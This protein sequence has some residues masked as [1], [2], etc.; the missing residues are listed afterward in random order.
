MKLKPRC[1]PCE[2]EGAFEQIQISVEDES[3]QLE[4][5][6]EVMDFLKEHSGDDIPPAKLGTLRNE[7]IR[8]ITEQEDPFGELKRKMNKTALELEPVA[9]EY[10]E[11]GSS[12]NGIIKRAIKVAAVGNSFDF[13]VSEHE[14][15]FDLLKKDF[16]QKLSEDLKIDHRDDLIDLLKSSENI[17]YLLDNPGEAIMD[18][19]FLKCINEVYPSAK[20]AIGARSAPVQDDIDLDMAET[21]NFQEYGDLLPS[22]RS[23]GY[24]PENSPP[25][26]KKFFDE[27]DL[28]ISKGQGNYEVLSE[29]E[30]N[31]GGKL[32]YLLRLKCTPVSKSL[33]AAKGNTVAALVK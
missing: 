1:I 22:G 10:I 4:V 11:K 8:D 23:T 25:K 14:I 26:I 17:L 6:R 18:R 19:L 28:L 27:A 7:L 31:F 33:G 24:N 13:S 3:E 16:K 29:H 5:L 20:I 15:N 2:L 12:E 30:G 9:E 32:A 21:L